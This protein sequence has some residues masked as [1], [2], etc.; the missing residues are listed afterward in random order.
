MFKLL[1]D[2]RPAFVI[3][4]FLLALALIIFVIALLM[5][6]TDRVDRGRI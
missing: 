6:A 2:H 1:F 3:G 5:A 4:E